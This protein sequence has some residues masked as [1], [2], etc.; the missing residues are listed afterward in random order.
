MTQRPGH[1]FGLHVD[2]QSNVALQ[3]QIR[4]QLT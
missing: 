1:A 4:R 2:P 3:S